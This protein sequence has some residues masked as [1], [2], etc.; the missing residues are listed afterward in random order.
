MVGRLSVTGIKRTDWMGRYWLR[1]GDAL[2]EA[3]YQPNAFAAAVPEEELLAKLAALTRDLGHFPIDAEVK[4]RARSDPD[5]PGHT[6]FRRLGH[7]RGRAEKLQAFCL[8][9]GEADVAAL[10]LPVLE[11]LA[12]KPESQ[13]E[14]SPEEDFGTVYLM[15]SGRYYKIGRTNALGR[16]ER[17]IALQL[18]SKV[19]VVHSIRTD[20]P[21][22]IE[23]YWHHRF[24]DR[25]ANGEWFN[26]TP[27]DVA[28]FRRRKFM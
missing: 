16:R 21:I 27:Q 13:E 26:L 23:A 22:G 1:W 4:L 10:C 17:E 28:A 19:D 15:K 11:T 7:T 20:D 2:R 5:F 8:D 25:R 12:A 3:G 24:R 18:P 6:T 14:A 9:R